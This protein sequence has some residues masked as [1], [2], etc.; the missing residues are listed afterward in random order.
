MQISFVLLHKP[1]RQLQSHSRLSML[2]WG[3][4][5]RD[6]VT[7]PALVF[8]PRPSYLGTFSTLALFSVLSILVVSATVIRYELYGAGI[9]FPARN[10]VFRID[11]YGHCPS[12]HKLEITSNLAMTSLSAYWILPGW[13]FVHYPGSNPYRGFDYMA[14]LTFFLNYHP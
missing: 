11:I 7:Y 10:R 9:S 5:I 1:S 14:T 12:W 3:L 2:F 8:A 6:L 13:T 4:I